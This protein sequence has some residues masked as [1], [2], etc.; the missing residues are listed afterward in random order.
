MKKNRRVSEVVVSSHQINGETE[1]AGDAGVPAV[2]VRDATKCYGVRKNR[3]AVLQSLD[4][5]VQKGIIYGLLGAS[6][7]GKT[8]LLSC[9][10]GRRSLNSGTV[11]VFG[12]KPGS[13]ESGIPGPRVGYMPQ[14]LALYGYFTIKETLQYFGRIYNLKP[15]FVN[16]QLEF[17]SNLLH[18]P[19]SD[20][21]VK[22]LSGGQQRRV[23]FAVALF[24]EPELL[25][26]DEP[27]VGVDPLLRRS[28]WDHLI[29]QSVDHGRTV[30]VTTHYI[31]EARQANTIGMMRSGRLLAEE[32][33][34]NLLRNYRLPSLEEVFLK[35]CMKDDGENRTEPSQ[36]IENCT[37][38]TL[39]SVT[40][41]RQ[42]VGG[43]T[44][45]AFDHSTSQTNITEIDT[46]ENH[47]N[48]NEASIS[49]ADCFGNAAL[50]LGVSSTRPAN[51]SETNAVVSRNKSRLSST[52][53]MA[54]PSVHRL[55]A[56]I[57]K[58]F[59]LTFR[60]VGIF[61]FIYFMPAFQA[62]VFNVTLG[63]EPTGLKM[64]IVNDELNPSQGR[65]CN[66]TTD[67]SYSMLSC[68]YLR[69]IKNNIIQVPY[70]S[71]SDALEAGKN[72]HVWGLIH[73]GHNF[74][75]EFEVRQASGDSASIENIIRSQIGINMDSTNQQIDL[76]IEKWLLE[77]FGDFFK[78]LMRSCQH[79]PEAG[80]IPV[81]FLDPV[82]GQKDTPYTEFMAPGLIITIVYFMA[83]SLTSGVLIAERKQGLLDRC[84]VAGVQMREI[85]FGQLISQFTV[86]VGQ[87][88][89]VFMC[90]L[91]IFN[92][93]CHGNLALAVFITFLQGLVGMCFGL[94]IATV[95]D[96]EISALLL[97]QASFL[98]FTVISGVCWPIEGMPFYLRSIAYS[99][100]LTYAIE[101]LRSIF[102]RGW[103]VERPDV[104]A[105]IF[106][107]MTWI[108]ILLVLC[109]IVIRVRKYAS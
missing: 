88:A 11:L 93:S 50:N 45:L 68:R 4:M 9:M 95:C 65:V 100:P 84:L 107:S 62:I 38:G 108:L 77:A 92:I 85:L 30:I 52:I 8:T 56:L 101:S 48:S 35:L 17:L 47:C 32:S 55:G 44:N 3:C 63:H 96:N 106:I 16:A 80:Y 72:G 99:M 7:C 74:T 81:V 98:P 87:T 28:I 91:L 83:V 25:I 76:F 97:S 18:L 22:T 90:M 58:N 15:A 78:D 1:S 79:E 41:I 27:T 102:S 82:Y 37:N 31:E 49:P 2:L 14:E 94:L 24:H 19:S 66:Y 12:H 23:S 10:V 40:G 104:F 109:M 5:S 57:R 6:G 103:G 67:C 20:R 70:E 54:L 26:L 29:R 53:K 59:L 64:G 39:R 21:F 34:D 89:L 69:Y 43:H 75:E 61:I 36:A 60:N 86:M 33:P 105:G 13:P 46:I 51:S 73:F 42:P 71:V